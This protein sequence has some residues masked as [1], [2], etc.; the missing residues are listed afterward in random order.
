M[1]TVVQMLS[2][3]ILADNRESLYSCWDTCASIEILGTFVIGTFN[4]NTVWMV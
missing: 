2:K 3:I 1:K 4:C